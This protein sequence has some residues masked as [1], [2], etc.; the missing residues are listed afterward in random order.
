MQRRSCQQD[1]YLVRV[2]RYLQHIAD[3]QSG[4]QF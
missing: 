2:L 3:D 1:S 4:L